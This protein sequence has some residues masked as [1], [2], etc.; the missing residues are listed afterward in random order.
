MTVE[1]IPREEFIRR[2]REI[3]P[4]L[5]ER[6][7]AAEAERRISDETHRAFVDAGFY[8]ILQPRRHGGHETDLG[9]MVDIAAELGR[10]CG[11]SCWIFT[12]VAMQA[13]V[14]GMKDP[15]A[16]QE[17]WGDDTNALT[18]SA[19]K[20]AEATVEIV[21]GGIVVDGVWNYSSGVD[22]AE[23]INLQIFLR[24]ENGPPEHRFAAVH[25]SDFEVIDDWFVSG[26]AATGSRSI[27][28]SRHFIPDY[29]MISSLD[30]HGGPTAGSAVNP[31]VL[32]RMPFWGI[33]AKLFSAPTIGIARGA[34]ELTEGDIESRIGMG[35]ARLWEQPTVQVRLAESSGEIEAAWALL[36]RDCAE[37]ERMTEVGEIPTVLRRTEWRRNNAYAVVLCVRAVDRLY[38]LSGMRGMAPDSDIQRAWRDIHAAATQVALAWDPAAANYGRARFGMPINDPRV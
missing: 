21:D 4:A 34:L 28:M 9:L 22:F 26:M 35:G 15:R 6:A 17:V 1:D 3:A 25:K 27:R 23:W 24:P 19:N 14:N 13:L 11:S 37:A 30:M 36:T 5:R 33:G 29:R 20:S 12:N 32:Y 2:A 18:A 31:G 38:G 16:Q 7:A 8:R 10:G